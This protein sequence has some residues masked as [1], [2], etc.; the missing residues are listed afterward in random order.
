MRGSIPNRS[1]IPPATPP[2]QRSSE[3]EMPRRR[4]A[5]KKLSIPVDWVGGFAGGPS[6]PTGA[7]PFVG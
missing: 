2:I 6:G 4:T 7:G 1:A 3:R 5:S